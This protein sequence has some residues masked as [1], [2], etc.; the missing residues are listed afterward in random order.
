[1]TRKRLFIKPTDPRTVKVIFAFDWKVIEALQ[2]IPSRWYHPGSKENTIAK[3][4]VPKLKELLPQYEF[5]EKD[6]VKQKYTIT[7]SHNG[8]TIRPEIQPFN[9]R[10]SRLLFLKRPRDGYELYR[11]LRDENYEVDLIDELSDQP[12]R[13]HDAPQLYPYQEDCMEFVRNNDYTG[14]VSLDMGLGK[15][16][17]ACS[18]IRELGKAPVL[19][20]APSSLLYQW[21]GELNKHYSFDDVTIVTSKI[22]PQRRIQSFFESPITITNY[23]LLRTIDLTKL[24][25]Y[26]LL[27]LDECQRVKNWRTKV[28]QSISHLVAKRVLGLSGTPVENNIAELYNITD[29]IQ[30]AFFGTQRKFLQRYVNQYNQQHQNLEEVYQKLQALMFRKGK[31]EVADQL[32]KLTKKLISVQLTKKEEKGY[33]AMLQQCHED[34]KGVLGAMANAKVFSSSAS[35]RMEDLKISSKEKE[36]VTIVGELQER[37]VVFSQYKKEVLRLKDIIEDKVPSKDVY[38]MSGETTKSLRNLEIQNFLKSDGGILLMTEVGTHG[39]NLQAADTCINFDLPWTY[40]RLD[41]RVGRIQRIGSEHDKN[42]VINMVSANTL[43]DHIM[44]VIEHK[45]EL[46]DLSI[47]GAKN[48]VANAFKEDLIGLGIDFDQKP[49]NPKRTMVRA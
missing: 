8:F 6:M 10:M 18:S 5:V 16:I 36:L 43:D 40:A 25:H 37:S 9:A 41:Q 20:V 49:T 22:K 29:Q 28:A 42:L 27:V 4:D 39:L 34:G 32:P 13:L 15:T 11:I 19:I 45:K 26:E 30:P 3:K 24:P 44:E 48:Y 46:F 12:L 14:L 38:M 2:Q 21:K 31:K 33:L 1:M 23:E 7:I 35:L 47:D 17:I